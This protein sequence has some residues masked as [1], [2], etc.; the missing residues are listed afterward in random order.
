M[1]NLFIA[2]AVAVLLPASFSSC[3]KK[4]A[5]PPPAAVAAP[6]PAKPAVK[7]KALAALKDMAKA[8]IA[9][10]AETFSKMDSKFPGTVAFGNALK[11]VDASKLDADALTVKSPDF[12]RATMELRSDPGVAFACAHLYAMQGNLRK[13]DAWLLLGSPGTDAAMKADQESLRQAVAAA[14]AELAAAVKKGSDMVEAK[15]ADEAVKIYG[16]VIADH[17]QN[18]AAFYGKAASLQLKDAKA[19]EKERGELLAKATALYPFYPDASRK[20]LKTL[21]ADVLPFLQ[22]KGALKD[23]AAG[24]EKL[25]AYDFAAQAFWMLT[26]TGKAQN[27]MLP[28]FYYN[29]KKSGLVT[30]VEQT[31]SDRF[32]KEVEQL[33]G[34]A[35]GQDAAE[36]GDEAE[37]SGVLHSCKAEVGMLCNSV[38]KNPKAALICVKR[39]QYEGGL[40]KGC[41]KFLKSLDAPEPEE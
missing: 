8:R 11:T 34:I 36:A 18:V 22:G 33:E 28:H 27:Q 30:F 14:E 38:R 17:P 10:Y 37:E 31:A 6:A 25:G 24:C 15:M 32:K 26:L 40:S 4:K 2:L 3:K 39:Y 21:S 12:W 1:K 20:D 16:E 5:E 41:R 35:S 19:A 9:R 13:A 7:Y 29:L 23:F